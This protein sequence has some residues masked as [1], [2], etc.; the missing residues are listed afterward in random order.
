MI[1]ALL[2]QVG[3]S[4]SVLMIVFL[5]L[6]LI[7]PNHVRNDSTRADQIPYELDPGEY[8]NLHHCGHCILQH[9]SDLLDEVVV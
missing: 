5:K 4:H 9:H 6:F 3:V 1:P 8:Q 7:G 2:V